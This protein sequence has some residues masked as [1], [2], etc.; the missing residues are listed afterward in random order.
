MKMVELVGALIG[1]GLKSVSTFI[2]SGNVVFADDG[3]DPANVRA[4]IED[5]IEAKFGFRADIF[6]RSRAD[7]QAIAEDVA[8]Q[9]H[10]SDVAINIAFIDDSPREATEQAFALY[11]SEIERFVAY[12]RHVIWLAKVKMSETPFFYKGIK[13]KS[14]PIMTVRNY[15]T[16]ERMLAKW[17]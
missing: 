15:N 1:L 8:A 9:R 12:D 14:L 17:G 6:L 10:E 13:S 2:A 7:L 3:R 11:Q 16:I 4:I 5:G